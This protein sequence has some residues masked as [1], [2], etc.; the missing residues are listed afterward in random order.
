MEIACR[1]MSTV[2]EQQIKDT[3]VFTLKNV[4]TELANATVMYF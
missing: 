1:A 2:Q 4:L 3:A